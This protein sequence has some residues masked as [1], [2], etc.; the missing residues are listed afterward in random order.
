MFRLYGNISSKRDEVP[1]LM[2]WYLT[3]PVL[4]RSSIKRKMNIQRNLRV[5]ELSPLSARKQAVQE[6]VESYQNWGSISISCRATTQ[7][8][9]HPGIMYLRIDATIDSMD[10]TKQRNFWHALGIFL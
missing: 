8:E 9:Y 6:P 7:W 4:L 5:G 1:P 2:G 10:A 3:V